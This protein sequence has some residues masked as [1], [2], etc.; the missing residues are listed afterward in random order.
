MGNNNIDTLRQVAG[1]LLL[2]A[3]SAILVI[4]GISLALAENNVPQLIPTPIELTTQIPMLDTATPLPVALPTNTV[5]P[6]PSCAPPQNWV[7]VSVQSGETLATIAARYQS[8]SEELSQANCLSSTELHPDSILYVPPPP[9][10]TASTCGHPSGWVQ[11]T[12]KTGN[13]MFNISHAYG[14]SISELQHANCIVSNQYNLRVGQTLWVPNVSITRT[15][16]ASATPTLTFVSIIF[17]TITYTPTST[18]TSTATTT[19]T[20]TPPTAT[21]TATATITSFPTS[22][23]TP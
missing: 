14:I 9:I 20:I 4:G 16:L 21:P 3:F 6:S 13:T 17:P 23:S 7:P 8:T 5:V 19:D 1:S 15:P 22:T 10:N 2:A 11:Y 12:V 18:P